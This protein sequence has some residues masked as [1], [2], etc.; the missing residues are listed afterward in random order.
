[1]ATRRKPEEEPT[2]RRLP[3]KTPE[4]RE[5]Q[6]VGLAF[7]LAEKQLLDGTASAAVIV[8][9]MKHGTGRERLER[10]KI[11]NETNLLL[12]RAEAAA[13]EAHSEDIYSEA[14]RAMSLY[15]GQAQPQDDDD[16]E[17]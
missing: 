9:L 14:L 7:D 8:A 13:R 3:A 11:E 1:M 5:H 15:T 12:I 10:M 4:G 6:L 16:Y 17:D 2:N